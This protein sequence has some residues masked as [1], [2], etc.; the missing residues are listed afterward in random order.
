MLRPVPV[1]AC[2]YYGL[3]VILDAEGCF[4]TLKSYVAGAA[5]RGLY[6]TAQW[7]S[8]NPVAFGAGLLYGFVPYDPD[9]VPIA[10]VT[11]MPL[12]AFHATRALYGR[13]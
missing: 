6:A 10:T 2:V 3:A 12:T 1:P 5:E 13:A 8:T 9:E 11:A 7:I 4:M